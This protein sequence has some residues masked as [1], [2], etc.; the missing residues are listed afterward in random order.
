MVLTTPY[1]LAFLSDALKLG[2]VTFD[3]LRNDEYSGSGDGRYWSAELAGPLWQISVALSARTTAEARAID[4]KIRALAGTQGSFLFADPTYAPAGRVVPGAGVTIAG[5]ADNRTAI[6]LS[7][8]PGGYPVAAGDRI[9][10]TAAGKVWLAEIS[11]DAVAR[12]DGTTDALPVYPEVPLWLT[13][14][15]AVELARPVVRVFVPPDGH[16]PFTMRLGFYADSA[17]LTLLQ[18]V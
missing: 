1:P 2:D 6:A 3:L 13:A 17:A 4:A 11:D 18:R 16:T 15:M 14:G 9:S 5:F 8:L 7:G 12:S 10:V